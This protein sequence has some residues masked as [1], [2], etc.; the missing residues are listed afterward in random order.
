MAQIDSYASCYV[1]FKL[2]YKDGSQILEAWTQ[3]PKYIFNTILI[4]NYNFI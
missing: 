4:N 1:W 3:V 2:T